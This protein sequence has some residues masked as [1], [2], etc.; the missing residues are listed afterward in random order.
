MSYVKTIFLI[1]LLSSAM[2][3]P[4]CSSNIPQDDDS[5]IVAKINDYKLTVADFEYETGDK[6]PAGLS[7]QDLKKAKEDLLERLITKKLLIQEA[8]KQNFDKDTAFVKE[9]EKYWEQALL[10]L[11]YN[12]RSQELVREIGKDEVDPKIR[13]AKVQQ[14]LNEWIEGLKR[15]A[16]IKRYEENL[17]TVRL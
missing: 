4:A 6:I 9:I 17:D 7:G 5:K 1:S 13:D 2:L 16:D 3:I 15:R 12:K 10:K 8:Q 14:A 11:L